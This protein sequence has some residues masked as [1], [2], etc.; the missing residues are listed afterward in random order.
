MECNRRHELSNSHFAEEERGAWM[1]VTRSW[2]AELVNGKAAFSSSSYIIL[3]M[4]ITQGLTCHEVW[5][6]KNLL[7]LSN[8]SSLLSISVVRGQ[9]LCKLH[10]PDS[11]ACCFSVRFRH[12]EALERGWR[13]ESRRKRFLPL[14]YACPCFSS[15][16]HVCVPLGCQQPLGGYSTGN[17]GPSRP[18][19][20]HQMGLKIP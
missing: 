7:S 4:R 5:F 9:G 20:L 1:H 14:R 13:V 6:L 16:P 8:E 15:W 3:R 2:F 17:Q 12:W 19:I 11:F 10:F 18:L